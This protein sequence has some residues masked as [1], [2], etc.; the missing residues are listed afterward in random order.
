MTR[1]DCQGG[2]FVVLSFSTFIAVMLLEAAG[3]PHG[4]TLATLFAGA[5]IALG[6]IFTG[7]EG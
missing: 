4:W 1:R 6:V 2:V 3:A 5:A 7:L